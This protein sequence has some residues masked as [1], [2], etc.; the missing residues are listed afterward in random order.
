MLVQGEQLAEVIRIADRQEQRQRGAVAGEG[1]VG[2]QVVR[3]A[4]SLQ[5]LGSLSQ[6]Q[7]V[8][9]CEKVGH[10]LIVVG[11]RLP[12]Q[13]NGVLRGREADELGRDRAALVHELVEGVLP[14]RA[15][16]PEVDGTGANR[17]LLACHRDALAVGFHV[18]LL[19]VRHEARESLAIRQHGAT[20]VLEDADIPDGQQAHDEGQIL[21]GWGREEVLV[22]RSAAI[23]ELHNGVE[24]VLQGQR[25]N[26]NGTP[27]RE[28]ATDPI[29]EA[30]NV[31]RVNAEGGSLVQSRRASGDVLG[32]AIR[33]TKLLDQPLLDGLGVEHCLSRREGLRDNQHERGLRVEAFQ[34][35]L[36]V[37]GVN[38]CEEAQ[39]SALCRHGCLGIRLQ[40]LEHEL[41][42]QIGAADADAH[43]VRQLLAGVADPLALAHLLG[44][45]LHAVQHTPHLWHDVFAIHAD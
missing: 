10:Q 6:S 40:G 27:A 8:R 9:L 11:H 29:P 18:Q 28:A 30:E 24:A 35:T 7:C 21:F 45:G 33:R 34:G 12:G 1:L 15:R 2:H 39:A 4:I 16:L 3:H 20:L 23:M 43:D 44:E 26:A 19:D 37:D 14:V 38:V 17:H 42:A 41:D 22:H 25:Q 32:H 5:L 36:H 13:L 31:V